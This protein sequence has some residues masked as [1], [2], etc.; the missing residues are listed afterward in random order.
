MDVK[1]FARI[2]T[3]FTDKP[4]D[5]EKDRNEF[6]LQI[7]DE[8]IVAKLKVQDGELYVVEREQVERAGRWI[9]ER[10]ARVSLLASRILEFIP[11]ERHLVVPSC[12]VTRRLGSV[13]GDVS[14]PRPSAIEEVRELLSPGTAGFTNAVYLTANAGEGKTTL[15]EALARDQAKRYQNRQAS[16][17]LV[18]IA[19]RGRNL[20]RFDEAVLAS[21]V[22]RL[23][24]QFLY[25]DAFVELVKLGYI[26]PAFDGFEELFVQTDTGG[27]FSA[28]GSLM[29]LLDSQ[30]S[31]LISTRTAYFEFRSMGAQ[32]RLLD[33]M[34]DAMPSFSKVAIDKWRR[35][36]FVAYCGRRGIADGEHIHDVLAKHF[37]DDHPFLTRAVLVRSL[38]GELVRSTSDASNFVAA[39]ARDAGDAFSR[40]VHA[41]VHREATEKW[42]DYDME[43][44]RVLLSPEQHHRLLSMIAEEMWIG[45]TH[46]IESSVLATVGDLFCAEERL[47][48][49]VVNQ[50]RIRIVQHA[51]LRRLEGGSG[52]LAFEHIEFFNYYLGLSVGRC[53]AAARTSELRDL[54]RRG[55]LAEIC[56]DAAVCGAGTGGI[57]AAAAMRCLRSISAG[58]VSGAY[59]QTN[60]GRIAA[61]LLQLGGVQDSDITGV[62]FPENG[63]SGRRLVRIR[64]VGCYFGPTD[65]VGTELVGCEF[66]EC[67]FERLE[68]PSRSYRAGATFD[69]CQFWCVAFGGAD[70]FV[71]EFYA[72]SH[73]SALLAEMGLLLHA[74]GAPAVAS[75]VAREPRLVV[76]L[77]VLR[78]FFRSPVVTEEVLRHRVPTMVEL[79]VD[80]V[81]PAL[82]RARILVPAGGVHGM[83]AYRMNVPM[84]AVSEALQ[85]ADSKFDEFLRALARAPRRG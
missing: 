21:L 28:L 19:L 38:L 65:L 11:E 48:A 9:A 80:E 43:P 85:A 3:A 56:C 22:Q 7:R 52:A 31:V 60:A 46:E 5:V 40:F 66:I 6:I 63:L 64:F 18:P 30:G 83:D 42:I 62:T 84:G 24:F 15:I 2:V 53:L 23:R 27:G 10:L 34:G 55:P 71:G 68:F 72:P 13:A 54:L 17:I 4:S 36:D 44:A 32:V 50:V 47:P 77:R 25:F 29:K 12:Q 67:Q 51:M 76:A 35:D 39:V 59:L 45:E 74:S 69:R 75:A 58:E 79:L 8:V 78:T 37:G 1:T 26:V 20:I 57:D 81:L 49:R 70:E 33:A 14:E 73:I 61:R 16:W 41:M 82:L